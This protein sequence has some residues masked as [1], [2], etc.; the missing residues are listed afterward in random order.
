MSF[1][2]TLQ[3]CWISAHVRETFWMSLPTRTI[4]SL[5]SD[6]RLTVTPGRASTTRTT[7]SP[8]KLRISTFVSLLTMATLMGKCAY[9][10]RILYLKPCGRGEGEGAG[11]S[12]G[13]REG[14]AAAATTARARDA[15]SQPG[16]RHA[17]ELLWRRAGSGGGEVARAT[18]GQGLWHGPW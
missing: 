2:F 7:F 3:I 10:K 15:I 13:A 9:T 12:S 17:E 11:V 4:S 6:E 5:T 14:F 8:R 1:R 18:G 16:T